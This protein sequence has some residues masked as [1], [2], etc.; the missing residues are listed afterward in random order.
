[1]VCGVKAS[2]LH[3][4][5]LGNAK[6]LQVCLN[7]SKLTFLILVSCF[8]WFMH[9]FS[10][11]LASFI[12]YLVKNLKFEI[13][14]STFLEMLILTTKTQMIL[15]GLPQLSKFNPKMIYP[16]IFCETKAIWGW[17]WQ[18]HWNCY[19][20]IY[21]PEIIDLWYQ[22]SKYSFLTPIYVNFIFSNDSNNYFSWKQLDL[23]V[24]IAII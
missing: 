8:I 16:L 12:L 18:K 2:P 15:C 10:V 13:F 24:K 14:T 19:F 21:L 9:V 7:N 23:K 5:T 17:Y 22:N 1:M 20:Q 3:V 11:K 6:N 4:G